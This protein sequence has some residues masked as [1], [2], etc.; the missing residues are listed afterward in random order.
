MRGSS[1]AIPPPPGASAESRAVC[2]PLQPEDVQ[3]FLNRVFLDVAVPI[4]PV[5]MLAALQHLSTRLDCRENL[6]V[7]D[8]LADKVIELSNPVAGVSLAYR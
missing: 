8:F 2:C 1:S 3:A 6:R 5:D 4:N 7:L